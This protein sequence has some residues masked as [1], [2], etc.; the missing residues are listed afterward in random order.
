MASRPLI[1][2]HKHQGSVVRLGSDALRSA[3][4]TLLSSHGKMR[5]SQLFLSRALFSKVDFQPLVAISSRIVKIRC[6][7]T[8]LI[9]DETKSTM[10]TGSQAFMEVTSG[11]GDISMIGQS[12]VGFHIGWRPIRSILSARVTM[13]RICGSLRQMAL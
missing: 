3:A 10:A 9:L 11:D 7:S 2:T 4:Y 1:A 8:T 12:G 6:E 5:F 13:N